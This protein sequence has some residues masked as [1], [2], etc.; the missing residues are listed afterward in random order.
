MKKAPPH[1][2]PS[3]DLMPIIQWL[4]PTSNQQAKNQNYDLLTFP[5]FSMFQHKTHSNGASE[6]K[7]FN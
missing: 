6:E 3:T 4:S 1:P 7:I 5:N 2:P